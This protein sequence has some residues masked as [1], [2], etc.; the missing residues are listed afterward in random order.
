MRSH[1]ARF[2]E[3]LRSRTDVE[4]VGTS[5]LPTLTTPDFNDFTHLTLAGRAKVS[6]RLAEILAGPHP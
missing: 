2:L 6:S 1:Y 4:F 5:D 3:G